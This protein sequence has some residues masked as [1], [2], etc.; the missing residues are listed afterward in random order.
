MCGR[1][2]TLCDNISIDHGTQQRITAHSF[3]CFIDEVKMLQS[4][5]NKHGLKV[6]SPCPCPFNPFNPVKRSEVST[7]KVQRRKKAAFNVESRQKNPH[8]AFA[9]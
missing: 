9:T 4:N 8:E 2:L 3:A 7:K 6:L 5:P 1:H